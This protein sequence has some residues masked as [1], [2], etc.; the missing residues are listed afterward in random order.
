MTSSPVA[1]SPIVVPADDDEEVD[2]EEEEEMG[3]ADTFADYM[4]AKGCSLLVILICLFHKTHNI[5]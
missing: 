5:H 4:P 3:Y 2:D 1:L